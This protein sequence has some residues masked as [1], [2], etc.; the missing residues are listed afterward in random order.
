MSATTLLSHETLSPGGRGPLARHGVGFAVLILPREGLERPADPAK[1]VAP[2]SESCSPRTTSPPARRSP[3]YG[4]MDNGTIWGHGAYLGRV[5]RPDA[6]WPALHLA[7]RIAQTRSRPPTRTSARTKAR[8]RRRSRV[9]VRDHVRRRG[10]HRAAGGQQGVRRAGHLLISGSLSRLERRARG[11]RSPTRPSCA[12]SRRSSRGWA[13]AAGGPESPSRPPT[14]SVRP[15][16]GIT[17]PAARCSGRHQPGVPARQHRHRAARVQ[18][19]HY[20]LARR[21]DVHHCPAGGRS[22]AHCAGAGRHTQIHGD[23]RPALLAQV[24][25]GGTLAHYRAERDFTDSTSRRCSRAITTRMA[26]A[27]DD[28][29]PRLCRRGRSS[30]PGAWRR[31]P[32]GQR[33]SFTC[34]SGLVGSSRV[35]CAASGPALTIAWANCSSGSATRAGN[36]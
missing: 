14:T 17:T 15:V 18:Q 3:Q 26:P 1:A 2:N 21:H 5:H 23:R 8:S 33:P 16:G 7:G 36:A 12:S 31:R 34:C 4:L 11:A 25:I 19:V 9:R 13:A 32:E 35:A 24:L 10:S 27:D 6:P 22:S 30:L 20:W 29:L 28:L